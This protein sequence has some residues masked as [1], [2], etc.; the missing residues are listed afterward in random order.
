MDSRILIWDMQ[1]TVN[2]K[3]SLENK[4]EEQFCKRGKGEGGRGCLE[5]K[6]FGGECMFGVVAASH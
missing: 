4:G 6:F 1:T 2:P 5:R 3:A